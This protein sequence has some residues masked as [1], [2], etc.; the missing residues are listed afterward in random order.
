MAQ[1]YGELIR[2][3][4]QVS[5]SDLTPTATGLVYFNSSTGLKWY[6]GSAWKIAVDLNSTQSLGAKTIDATC[7]VNASALPIVPNTKGG[8]G[9]DASAFAGIVKASAGV[10]SASSLVNADISNSAAIARS[11]IAS[12]TINH[13][14]IN[15]GTG[16]LSSEATLAKSRGGSGQDN[17][18]LT[19]PASGTLA[20]LADITTSQIT[21]ILAT[22]K[23]GTGVNSTATFPSSGTVATLADITTTQI[24]GTLSSSKGGLGTN[25]SAFTGVVKASSGAFSA[26]TVVNADVSATAAIDGTKISPDFGAQNVTTTGN[27]GGTNALITG[28]EELTGIA[29]PSSPAAGKIRVY[30]KTDNKLYKLDSAG[31]EA[32]V[33]SGG[34]SA[35]VNYLVDWYDAT[36]DIAAGS[37]VTVAANG[38][39]TVSGSFPSVTSAWYAD[40][41]SGTSAIGKSGNNTLRG[42]TNY[43]TALSGAST[44]GATF[45]QSPV[46]NIDGEDLGKAL[47]VQF[48]LSGNTTD[49][50]W[51]VVAVRYNS[52]GTFQ[53]LIPIAGN[54]S[55]MTGTPSAKLPLGV[56]TFNGFFITGSTA[57]DVYSIRWRRRNGSVAIR[58]DS[59]VVGPQQVLQGAIVTDWV[60]GGTITIT[61]V[62]TN[63]T[64]GTV[65]QDKWWYRRV[66]DTYEFRMEYSQS[67][68][69]TDGSGQYL[70][71]LP[72]GLAIDTTKIQSLSTIDPGVLGSFITRAG[73]NYYI[74]VVVTSSTAGTASQIRL[75]YT[76]TTAAVVGSA[77]NGLASNPLRYYAEFRA[78]IAGAV[79]NTQ[80]AARAVEEY[81]Y[82]TDTT[83][84]AGYTQ[85]DNGLYGYGPQGVRFNAIASTTANSQSAYRVRFQTPIQKTD[86]LILEISETAGAT[87]AS[88]GDSFVAYNSESTSA[89]GMWITP[90]IN[91]TT[92][93][94]VYFGNQGYR[95]SGA[96]FAAS[97]SAWSI[98]S[99]NANYFWRLKKISSGAAVG[100]P[101]GARNVIGDTTGTAVPAGYIAEKQISTSNYTVT[102]TLGSTGATLTLGAG[103]WAL[104]GSIGGNNTGPS[105]GIQIGISTSSSSYDTTTADCRVFLAANATQGVC[106]GSIGPRIVVLSASQT[107]YLIAASYVGNFAGTAACALQAVRIA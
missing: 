86:T 52:S 17:S 10:F 12:G 7:S 77:S 104:Y 26:A 65:V 55:T 46:F 98:F 39:V 27:V 88:T 99:S 79:A 58:L 87:W 45:V 9:L 6:T 43:L 93:V 44:S 74:G 96:S 49:D 105:T 40:A 70:F 92:D 60:D 35:G 68:A 75:E 33:G 34:G 22:S 53:E 66:G 24:T 89:Y 103:V 59:L 67:T 5:A 23:G 11:K 50:D 107:Y 69:G 13:V 78:P 1:I 71:S 100:F 106:G 101:V 62:T 97:G 64:K 102:T 82:S 57:S 61:G 38:N 91:T 48:D 80:Q 85:T 15:D 16:L 42:T 4:L 36:K 56:K 20:V 63:P 37:V 72:A 2:A 28:Y 19:F 41:T 94:Y 32:A 54:V 47:T 25:A 51:D 90:V 21:G 14:I 18:S 73:A 31:N 76:T 95:S 81:A 83:T 8:L 84:T 30:A 3:Q 29:T